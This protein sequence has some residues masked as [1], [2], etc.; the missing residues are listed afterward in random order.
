MN[1]CDTCKYWKNINDT[2]Y[3]QCESLI[4]GEM[5]ADPMPKNA[6]V[7]LHYESAGELAFR[8]G[9]KFGCVHH[10]EDMEPKKR[11]YADLVNPKDISLII[12]QL[13]I[14]YHMIASSRWLCVH[15]NLNMSTTFTHIYD[16]WAWKTIE[17]ER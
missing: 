1:T 12:L 5:F 17:S 7:Y 2:H 8:P 10:R 14:T 6:L 4:E 15:R 11:T 16:V 3:C 9:P 13:A